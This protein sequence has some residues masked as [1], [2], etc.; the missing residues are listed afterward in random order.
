MRTFGKS[1]FPKGSLMAEFSENFGSNL[2]R[3]K[4]NIALHAAKVEAELASKSKSEF[5]ANMS[6]ELRTPLNAVIGF[7]DMLSTLKI[8]DPERVNQYSAYIR[9]AAEHLLSLIN[10]ILDVSKMQAGKLEV[11]P[12]LIDINEVMQGCELIISAKAKEKDITLSFDAARNLERVYADPLRIKQILINLLSNAVKF[13]PENG[14]VTCSSASC[15]NGYIS[16]T[17]SDTG[18]GMSE[19]EVDTALRPF[20]QV[21]AG[22]DKRYDGTGLG[23]PISVSLAKL[24]NG[25]LTIK[26][27]KDQGTAVSLFLPVAS[28]DE[29]ASN[30]IQSETKSND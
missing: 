18:P 20:G 5:I 10:D 8:S 13:T 7:S 4:S 2:A 26:S 23:L 6:H 12:E 30:S 24:H 19:K 14:Q 3:Q 29:Q 9:E 28:A 27:I 22:F 16:I 21:H 11:E 1:W 25:E 17:V 15:G